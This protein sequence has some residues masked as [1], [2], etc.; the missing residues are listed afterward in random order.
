MEFLQDSNVP[1]LKPTSTPLALNCKLT[2]EEGEL[3]SDPTYYRTMVGK[4][5]S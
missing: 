4:L 5:I 1:E 3:L 2:L